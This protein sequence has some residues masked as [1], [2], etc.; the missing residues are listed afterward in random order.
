MAAPPQEQL[1]KQD[2]ERWGHFRGIRVPGQCPNP[3]PLSPQSPLPASFLLLLSSL[4]LNIIPPHHLPRLSAH[5]PL[6][7]PTTWPALDQSSSPLAWYLMGSR[8]YLFPI[9]GTLPALVG[10]TQEPGMVTG[11]DSGAGLPRDGNSQRPSWLGVSLL[12]SIDCV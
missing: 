12:S 7:N 5:P 1:P 4:Q 8:F 3:I 2:G 11:R 6:S 9:P 10:M